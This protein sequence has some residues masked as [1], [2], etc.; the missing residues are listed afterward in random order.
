M[1]KHKQFGKLVF[2]HL[3][4]VK[5]RLLEDHPR[6]NALLRLIKDISEILLLTK[7]PAES[8]EGGK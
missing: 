2:K 7:A 6:R 5:I 8:A 3:H 4:D 1:R